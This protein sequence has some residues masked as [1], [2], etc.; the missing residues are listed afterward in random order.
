MQLVSCEKNEEPLAV[1]IFD[2][3]FPGAYP[4]RVKRPSLA[5]HLLAEMKKRADPNRN[6]I[7]IVVEND[8]ALE[9]TLVAAGAKVALHFDFYSGDIP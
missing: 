3:A 7:G 4:F 8:E 5:G 1:C 6:D 9:E 2:P